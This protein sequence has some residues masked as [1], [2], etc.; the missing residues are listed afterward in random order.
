MDSDIYICLIDFEKAFDPHRLMTEIL[1]RP[2]VDERVINM[3]EDIYTE[4]IKFVSNFEIKQRTKLKLRE[5]SVKSVFCHHSYL[6]YIRRRKYS[7]KFLRITAKV[8][9]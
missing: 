5:E 8:F 2:E 7:L 9:A 1:R 3:I 4:H 6:I